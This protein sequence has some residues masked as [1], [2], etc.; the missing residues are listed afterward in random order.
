[1]KLIEL[2]SP[3]AAACTIELE[4]RSGRRLR[5]TEAVAPEAIA[6]LL[7]VLEARS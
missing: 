3:V 7:A 1:L 2:A 4:L 5:F 6:R